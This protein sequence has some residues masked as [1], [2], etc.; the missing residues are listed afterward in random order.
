MFSI[1]TFTALAYIPS[2]LAL[3]MPDGVG[4]LP[5]LGWNSWNTF[6]CNINETV[7]LKTAEAMISKGFKTLGSSDRTAK[8]AGYEYLNLDD[9]WSNKTSRDTATHR[10]MPDIVKFPNG[11]NGLADSIH[12]L[13]LKL[14]IYSDA[15]MTICA[16]YP[17]SI[18]YESIDAETFGEWGVDCMKSGIFFRCQGELFRL[19]LR[20]FNPAKLREW[21]VYQYNKFVPRGLRLVSVEYSKAL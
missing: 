19:S 8:A 3:V 7:I 15:G 18:G 5:A 20:Y 2:S 14:G 21:H 17:A 12:A 1:L 6:A 13:G 10:I 16:G 9:C 4:K 11:I